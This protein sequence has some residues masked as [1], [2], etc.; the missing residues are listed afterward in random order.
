MRSPQVASHFV[1]KYYDVL[2][3]HPTFLSKFFKETS[4]ATVTLM[5]EHLPT[6]PSTDLDVRAPHSG[7]LPRAAGGSAPGASEGHRP[8]RA[9]R[10]G[11]AHRRRASTSSCSPLARPALPLRAQ[12]IQAVVNAT[13]A[14]AKTTIKHMDAQ[15]SLNGGVLLHVGGVMELQASAPRCT[16]AASA[17]GG[18]QREE[19]HAADHRGRGPAAVP[20]GCLG[21]RRRPDHHAPLVLRCWLAGRGA[22]VRADLLPGSSGERLLRAQRPAAPLPGPAAARRHGQRQLRQAAARGSGSGGGSSAGARRSRATGAS[23]SAG[24]YLAR[25]SRTGASSWGCAPP[26]SAPP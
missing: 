6:Q 3:Q 16:Q 19:Q 20:T 12:T 15:L 1:Q 10:A 8:R 23:A 21:S 4:T 13:V 17:H 9:A 14:G 7:L 11:R 5:D 18:E 24:S 26:A 22:L 2:H 25:C